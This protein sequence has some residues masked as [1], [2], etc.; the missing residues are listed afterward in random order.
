LQ[1]LKPLSVTEPQKGVFV[2]DLGQNI[3]GRVAITIPTKSQVCAGD[4]GRMEVV[5]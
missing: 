1:T 5:R 4:G 2:L 3:A